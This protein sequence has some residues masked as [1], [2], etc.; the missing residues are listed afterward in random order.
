MSIT[1]ATSSLLL[2]L[3][4]SLFLIAVAQ[5]MVSVESYNASQRIQREHDLPHPKQCSDSTQ[6]LLGF[7]AIRHRRLL[8]LL[9][10]GHEIVHVAFGLGELHLVHALARVPMQKGLASEH[11]R[12]LVAHALEELLDRGRVPDK[13]RRH[14]EAARRDRAQRRLDVVGDPFDKV[15]RVLVL[16]VAH[17][18]LDLLHR[19]LAAAEDRRQQGAE[20][21]HQMQDR[22]S[23]DGRAGQVSAVPE[24]RGGHHVLGVEHLLRQL[25]NGD[26]P[27]RVSA[28][29]GQRREADHEEVKTRERDHVDRQL[30][31]I[32]IELARETKAGRDA[33]HDGRDQVVQ[34]AIRRVRQ[35]QSSHANIVEG[36]VS[37][38]R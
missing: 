3:H 7:F 13:G 32:R 14:L 23:Q 35:L 34:V 17:L 24:I 6:N 19:H 26:G 29:A 2:A 5:V 27:E 18:I 22:H 38:E 11:G 28:P 25:R 37:Y 20:P 30:A 36:L 15:R 21:R 9:I 8:I 4:R 33:R 1:V 10:L 31:Q 16:D 12:E